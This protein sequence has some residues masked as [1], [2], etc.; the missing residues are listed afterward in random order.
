MKRKIKKWLAV[1]VAVAGMLLPTSTAFAFTDEEATQ[2]EVEV[3]VE[4]EE[5]IQEE[6]LP[7]TEAT[8][9][10][11]PGNGELL[12]DK[13]EDSTKQFL[14]VQTKNGNTFFLILDRSNN[15]E[16]VYMLSMVD[17][18]DLAEFITEE[19]EQESEPTAVVT[20]QPDTEQVIVETQKKQETESQETHTGTFF[21]IALLVAS[22][23]A[24]IYYFKVV[25]P[26]KEEADV[27]DEDL[28]FY[29][30]EYIKEDEEDHRDT[31]DIEE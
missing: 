3:P 1:F 17:E 7:Q 22:G 10:S 15:Q 29:G 16:N 30:G 27:E 23:C 5:P 25:K 24:G 20:P 13:S 18:N 4:T 21:A 12:D 14:T 28:E 6:V 19:K 26:K 9:F 8:P 11:V 2:Q 31:Q